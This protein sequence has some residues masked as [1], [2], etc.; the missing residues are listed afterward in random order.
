[1]IELR[2]CFVKLYHLYFTAY[3]TSKMNIPKN[4]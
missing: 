2:D 1:M 4:K 3:L